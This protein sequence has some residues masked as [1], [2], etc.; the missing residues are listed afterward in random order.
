PAE[1]HQSDGDAGS[2]R[3]V[4]RQSDRTSGRELAW[5][6]DAGCDRDHLCSPSSH[7]CRLEAAAWQSSPRLRRKLRCLML[8]KGAVTP[9]LCYQLAVA[10][11]AL[12]PFW[13][14]TAIAIP[15]DGD[16]NWSSV[17]KLDDWARSSNRIC[18]FCRQ[19]H[20]RRGAG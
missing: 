2:P 8:R 18:R 5:L 17:K 20:R 7:S 1:Q 3:P 15:Y 9:K 14:E 4:A 10:I 12:V 11:L 6:S 16:I 13:Q 19:T